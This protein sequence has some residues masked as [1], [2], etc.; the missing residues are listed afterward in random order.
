MSAADHKL[1]IRFTVRI[2]G[3]LIQEGSILVS[4]ERIGNFA[5]SKFPGGGLEFGE[6]PLDCLIRECREETGITVK[7][8]RHIYTSETF[9]QSALDAEEQ[10]IGI[11]Y[12]IEAADKDSIRSIDLDE[13]TEDFREK[14]NFIRMEWVKLD[15]E[16]E[17]ELSFEMDRLALR[18]YFQRLDR[19]NP[20][21]L[22]N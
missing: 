11:Y 20:L 19:Q 1:P 15:A 12:L 22:R 7:I 18:A 10:V 14:E 6:G 5:F 4:R 2:Y 16:T 17:R 3:L 8:I 9:I 21:H 13:K